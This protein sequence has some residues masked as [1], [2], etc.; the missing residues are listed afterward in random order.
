[1][2][3]F[4]AVSPRVDMF[5]PLS[6]REGRSNWSELLEIGRS[7]AQVADRLGYDGVWMGEHHFERDGTDVVPNPV[8]LGADIAAR[9]ERVR[10]C[11]GAVTLTLWHPLRVAE[12]LAM[13]DHFSGGRLE[14]AFSRGIA[15]SEIVNLN[16]EADRRGD[17]TRSKAIFAENLEVVRHAWAKDKFN[18]KGERHTFPQPGIQ[19]KSAPGA[20]KREG[21]TGVNGEMI[22]MS[23]APRPVQQPMP[24]LWST[25][26]HV[27][28]FAE[29]GAAGIGAITWYPTGKYLAELFEAH[30]RATEEATGASPSTGEGCALLRLTLVAKSDAEAREKFEPA[31]NHYFEFIDRVRGKQVWFDTDEDPDDEKNAGKKPFDLLMERGHLFVGSPQTVVE[32]ME[33]FGKSHG[34][35]HWLLAQTMPGVSEE[36]GDQ[37][38]ELMG[39]EVLPALRPS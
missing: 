16:P 24:P 6:N 29:A 32:R 4:S 31:L 12:D 2:R 1:M 15:A 7:R 18:W 33:A 36:A 19:Y 14:V 20:P 23:I 38:I 13:L 10:I 37:S 27:S 22:K 35:R 17:Q 11:M 30:R 28:G 21:Y 3:E 26:E 25:T 34:V 9:T 5:L 39:K 8:L